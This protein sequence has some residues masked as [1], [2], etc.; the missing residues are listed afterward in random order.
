MRIQKPVEAL[1]S[2][3]LY[4]LSSVEAVRLDKH[5]VLV[6][7]AGFEE[8]ATEVARRVQ[9]VPS[10]RVI[11]IRYLPELASNSDAEIASLG[12]RCGVVPKELVYDRQNPA[13]IADQLIALLD[14]NEKVVVDVSGMSRLLICQLVCSIMSE[15]SLCNGS[16]LLYTEANEY[17]PSRE[18]AES[19]I[20]K[21]GDE[22][23]LRVMLSSGVYEV[24][25]VP[26]LSSTAMQGQPVRL[27]AFPSFNTHQLTA[28]MSEIQPSEWTILNGVPHLEEHAWRRDVIR[29][30]NGIDALSRAD[31]IDV[32]TFDYR[33]TLHAIAVGYAA[34][35]SS[36]RLVVSPTGSKM[37]AVAVGICRAF[38]RDVQIVYPTP[39]A[40]A[41]PE[42]YTRGV[43]ALYSLPL[44]NFSSLSESLIPIA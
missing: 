43:R 33:E 37:Q 14:P 22:P 16:R 40:F 23:E 18:V 3:P 25:I 24:S 26:E 19:A 13:G 21:Y 15:P 35:A 9:T 44:G 6:L 12:I 20:D 42:D 30:L 7:T 36:E 32:S 38:L 11:A 17:P 34:H 8:R 1:K 41:A 28:L 5:D 31:E 27:M 10:K 29:R 4:E 2:L 39:R